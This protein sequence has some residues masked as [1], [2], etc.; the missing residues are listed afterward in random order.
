MHEILFE[1]SN[2]I[3]WPNVVTYNVIVDG[4]GKEA[5]FEEGMKLFH[6]ISNK[7]HFP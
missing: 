7:K 2:K 4:L 6:E 3:V 1:I 5:K